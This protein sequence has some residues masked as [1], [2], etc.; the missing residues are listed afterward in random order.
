MVGKMNSK[1]ECYGCE[2]EVDIHKTH[3]VDGKWCCENC[4]ALVEGIV[5]DEY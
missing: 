1:V 5:G 2:G 4:A 3:F